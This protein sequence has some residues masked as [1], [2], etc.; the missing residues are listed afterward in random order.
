MTI[1]RLTIAPRTSFRTPLQSDT[2]FGHLLWALRY[3]EGEAGQAQVDALLERYRAG[4]PPFLVSAGFPANHLPTPLLPY[5]PDKPS[6]PEPVANK[7]VGGFLNKSRMKTAYLSLEQWH[8]LASKLSS[9]A[10]S[11][12]LEQS[13]SESPRLERQSLKH[14]L[15]RTAVDRITGSAHEGRLFVSDEVFYRETARIDIWHQIF[16]EALIP[17]LMTWWRWV[18]ANGFG[19]RKS[20][21]HG[22]FQIVQPLHPADDD[23]PGTHVA[24]PNAFMSLSA[25]VPARDDPTDVCYRTRIKRGK[26]AEAYALGRPWKKPLL[27][28]EPGTLACLPTGEP[29]RTFYGRLIEDMHW[30]RPDIVQYGLG[31]PMGVNVVP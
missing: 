8:T 11:N 26:L 5:K 14:Y 3:S 12:I 13:E 9:D 15:T 7:V 4:P 17:D 1:Y 6:K 24:Q 31:F 28:F 19:K 29:L 10:L 21:G 2:I 23:F 22:V 25:W 27:M 18:E 20:A 30:T 16:D